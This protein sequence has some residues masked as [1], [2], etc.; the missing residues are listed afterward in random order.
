MSSQRL[1]V[2]H[3]RRA[4]STWKRSKMATAK[5]MLSLQRRRTEARF[6]SRRGNGA[7]LR[8]KDSIFL[9]C[10]KDTI[11]SCGKNIVLVHWAF[12]AKY[13][14]LQGKP[15]FNSLKSEINILEGSVMVYG[16]FIST[17]HWKYSLFLRFFLGGLYGWNIV[18]VVPSE[19]QGKGINHFYDTA[20]EKSPLQEL[21]PFGFRG[22][23]RGGLICRAPWA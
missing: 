23:Y 16:Y 13:S 22:L 20:F 10:K 6:Y 21:S 15:Y 2:S 4:F 14:L 11:T 5:A 3:N 9:H 19:L 17:A 1:P 12:Q 8:S 18:S 7:E